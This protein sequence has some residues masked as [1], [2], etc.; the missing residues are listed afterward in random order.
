MNEKLVKSVFSSD[1][2]H[3]QV[4]L[5]EI[6][7]DR[8]EI[9]NLCEVKISSLYGIPI[10]FMLTNSLVNGPAGPFYANYI[11]EPRTP[12]TFGMLFYFIVN[13]CL[14]NGVVQFMM[15]PI[16][17]FLQ[18]FT[19]EANKTAR[20]LSRISRRGTDIEKMVDKFLMKNIQQKPILTAYGFFPLNKRTLFKI[21]AAIFTY[22]VILI[23]FKD[24]ENTNKRLLGT[25]TTTM[26]APTV[27]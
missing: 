13:V 23:Q 3:Q 15:F 20:I 21:F 8:S 19:E 16:I 5:G 4:T 18:D 17:V 24:M 25:K 22:M 9:I 10:I 2:D 27:S 1:S 14:I 26:S 7:T 12:N 6:L 11:F